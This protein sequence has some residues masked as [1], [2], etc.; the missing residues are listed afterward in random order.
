MMHHNCTQ[1]QLSQANY[2]QNYSKLHNANLIIVVYEQLAWFLLY[3]IY[4]IY[5]YISM[6]YRLHGYI[7]KVYRL[8]IF[9]IFFLR[10]KYIYIINFYQCNTGTSVFFRSSHV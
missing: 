8:N 4:I 6:I 5:Q 7:S 3:I 2:I 9:Y 1:V 10:K